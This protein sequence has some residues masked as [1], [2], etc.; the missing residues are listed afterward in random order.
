MRYCVGPT[1]GNCFS[2]P[3]L[4][5][6]LRYGGLAT[7]RSTGPVLDKVIDWPSAKVAVCTLV[8]L[9]VVTVACSHEAPPL[10]LRTRTI[11]FLAVAEAVGFGLTLCDA[12]GCGDELLMPKAPGRVGGV[13]V[14]REPILKMY[15]TAMISRAT[16]ATNSRLLRRL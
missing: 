12:D 15:S 16:M 5:L 7:R 6:T 10:A 2:A 11:A 4:I 9:A 14:G 8:P 13:V 1:P 3:P